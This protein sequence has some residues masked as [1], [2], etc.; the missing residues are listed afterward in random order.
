VMYSGALKKWKGYQTLLE[1]AKELPSSVQVVIIGGSESHVAELQKTYP[2]VV[3]LGYQ[4][5]RDL[6]VNRRTA[7][8][9]VIPNLPTDDPFERFTSPLKVFT[10]MASGVPFVVSNVPI[11]REVLTER[12]ALFFKPGDPK[13]LAA[14]VEETLAHAGAAA[15]RAVQARVEVEEYTWYKRAQNIINHITR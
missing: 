6:A 8:V 13:D 12:T 4:P 3:F 1:A 9:L 5:Y 10:H 7:D 14:K 2:G 15:K 11:L